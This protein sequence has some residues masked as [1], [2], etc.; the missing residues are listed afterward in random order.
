MRVFVVFRTIFLYGME[1]AVI[2]IFDAV[3]PE[4]KPVFHTSSCNRNSHYD[5]IHELESPKLTCT[6]F[7]DDHCGTWF[8]SGYCFADGPDCRK[9]GMKNCHQS[10][11][12][13]AESGAHDE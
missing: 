9:R 3:R 2:E 4:V 13:V 7:P 8:R 6:F 5:F 12:L 10:L 1:R 11:V